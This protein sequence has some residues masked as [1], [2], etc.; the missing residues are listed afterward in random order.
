[1]SRNDRLWIRGYKDLGHI[2]VLMTT[3]A[4]NTVTNKVG[5]DYLRSDKGQVCI[6]A[7]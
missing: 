4:N 2:R 3:L 5:Y 1:M 6:K 7:V